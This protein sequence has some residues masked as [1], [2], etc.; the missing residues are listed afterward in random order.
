MI[1]LNHSKSYIKHGKHTRGD[2]FFQISVVFQESEHSTELVPQ[3]H[4]VFVDPVIVNL[5]PMQVE[6]V[7]KSLKPSLGV[8]LVKF[9]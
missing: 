2:Y 7:D 9:G 5:V 6:D 4:E 3:E 8:F 1:L